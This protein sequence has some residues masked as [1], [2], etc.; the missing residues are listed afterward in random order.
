[1]DDAWNLLWLLLIAALLIPL[2]QQKIMQVRRMRLIRAIE[3]ARNSRVI[4]LIHR[5]ETMKFFGI[6]IMKYIDINDSEEVLRAV[7]FTPRDMPIDLIVHTPGG[8]VLSSKQIA[9]AL[10]RHPAKVTVFVP[11]YAMSGGTLL[12]LAADEVAMDGNAV[13]GPVD[14]QVGKFPAVSILHAVEKKEPKDIDDETFV[15]AD[16]SN[17]ALKQVRD[18]VV[19]LV[20]DRLGPEEAGRIVAELTEGR[21]T[22][23]HPIFFEEARE[24]GINVT[25]QVPGTIYR[26]MDL[27]PQAQQQRP[28]VQYVPVPYKG[29]EDRGKKRDRKPAGTRHGPAG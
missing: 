7:R 13:L 25:N 27:F 9:M 22:H 29:D 12:C 21:R 16:I 19:A 5:Q 20:S 17:K 18:F 26:L 2:F 28:S 15:M 6:P 14:P 24:L 8:L 3:K 10:K 1:M 4:T 11:H 23:D